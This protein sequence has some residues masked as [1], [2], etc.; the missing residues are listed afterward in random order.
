MSTNK[1]QLL[2]RIRLRIYIPQAPLADTFVRETDWQKEDTLI[3]QDDLYAQTWDTNFGSS[4]FDAEH[5]INNQQD[6]TVEYE[7]TPQHE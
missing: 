7:P 4:P 2:H 5:E 3:A 6:D 1:N